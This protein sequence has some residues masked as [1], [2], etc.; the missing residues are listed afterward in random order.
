C[1]RFAARE[2]TDK[3]DHI[4]LIYTKRS[5]S[6]C[7]LTG[8]QPNVIAVPPI[9]GEAGHD[10]RN[11][12]ARYLPQRNFE[13]FCEGKLKPEHVGRE[14]GSFR[15]FFEKAVTGKFTRGVYAGCASRPFVK[16]AFFC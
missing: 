6:C 14:R 3:G 13:A 9:L 15:G 12:N 16:R 7:K 4:G 10:I 2:K 11:V 8:E 1:R 5:E